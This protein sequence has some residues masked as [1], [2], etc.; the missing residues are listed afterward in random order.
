MKRYEHAGQ[1]YVEPETAVEVTDEMLSLAEDT[2]TWFDDDAPID[3]E[4]FIDRLSEEGYLADGSRLD[5][6]TYDSPAINKIKRHVR[7]YRRA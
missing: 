3:W 6:E 2:C 5:F 4:E 1:V 7:E